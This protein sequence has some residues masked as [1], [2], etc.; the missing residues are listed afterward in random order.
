MKPSNAK[1][2]PLAGERPAKTIA[3]V[4]VQPGVGSA[5]VTVLLRPRLTAR[6]P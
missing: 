5:G 6:E 4:I 3:V 2:R 1:G